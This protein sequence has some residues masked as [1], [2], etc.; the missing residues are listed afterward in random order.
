MG[1][2]LTRTGATHTSSLRLKPHRAQVSK[3]IEKDKA[4]FVGQEISGKTLGVVGLGQIGARVVDAALALGMNVVGY[5]PVLSVEAA[6]M[7]PGDRMQVPSAPVVC[8]F[9]EVRQV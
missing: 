3:R 8:A 4:M 1:R 5:D 9:G 6:L 2:R 7:L